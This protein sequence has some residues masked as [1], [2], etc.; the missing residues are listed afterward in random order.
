MKKSD[1]RKLFQE[2]GK[3]GGKARAA[4]MTKQQRK[5]SASNASKARW[6]RAPQTKETA[7]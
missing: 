5:D 1:K 4:K 3:A 6:S 7:K 2:L